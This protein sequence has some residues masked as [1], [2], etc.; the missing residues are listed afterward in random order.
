M[1][2]IDKIRDTATSHDRLFFVEVMG[3]D[4]GFIALQAGIATG[5]VSIM[6]PEE[7]QTIDELIENLDQGR[8]NGKKSSI[9]IVAEGEANGGA[10]KVAEQVR[11]KYD[12][13]DIRVTILGHIQ[14]GG[15]PMALDRII[16]SRMGVEAVEALN[17]GIKNVMVGIKSDKMVHVPFED[18]IFKSKTPNKEKIRI[19]K[20][21]AR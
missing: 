17:K 18:A 5:V 21:L 19:A 1:D 4:S 13:Y 15:T 8:K 16:A 14:R 9:V 20:I 6:L 10:M 11:A 7:E 2:A 3:R 12:Y